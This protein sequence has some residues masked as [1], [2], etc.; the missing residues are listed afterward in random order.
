MQQF[1]QTAHF[2]TLEI[3]AL[4]L[5]GEAR[6]EIKRFGLAP[7][8]AICHVIQ[9]RLKHA[10][11]YGETIRAVCLKPYQFSCWNVSDP[12]RVH[13]LNPITLTQ[14]VYKKCEEVA[15]NCLH[16]AMGADFT[17]GSNHY[18]S[19]YIKPPAW[20][21]EGVFTGAVGTHNFYRLT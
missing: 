11:R 18:Y 15:F 13:L 5:Y 16:H 12:N 20:A 2:S 3:L 6:G 10:Q 8:Y 21:A 9:N 4:T 7:L 14:A 17:Q 1:I 19:Q